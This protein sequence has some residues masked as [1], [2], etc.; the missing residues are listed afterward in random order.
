MMRRNLFLIPWFVV[1]AG[2][3]WA[4]LSAPAEWATHA[5]N[6]YQVFPN[7]TYL[8]AS[9]WEA[10]LDIYKRRDT[11]G[12]QPT[13]IFFHGGGWVQGSKEASQMSLMPWLEMG[14]NVVNVEYRLGRVAL[15]PAAVEDG[16][17]ALRWIATRAKDYDIDAS[18]LVTSGESA[19]GHLAL[20]TGMIPESAGLDRQCPGM[21]LPKVAGI[22]DWYGITDVAELLD[23]VN[24]KPYAVQWLAS[25]PDREAIA[26]R[27]SP[28]TYAREGLP[29]ILM[30]Q[31][32]ADPT[33]PY[34]QSLRLREALTK[35]NVTNELVTVPGGKHG[36][37][38]PAERSMIYVKI[39]E[40]LA[41]NGLGKT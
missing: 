27:V 4:Q 14:W 2:F 17:C 6:E 38:T 35:A 29:P 26:R 22:V 12:P 23:G 7:V 13:L 10:K 37:F 32:D 19:G 11:T 36:G 20:T 34:T 39:R 25:M 5:T 15:A 40:F 30:I 1:M 8:V 9:N 24:R 33:V 21:P 3:G 31:G 28:L 41:K 16:L 18:R